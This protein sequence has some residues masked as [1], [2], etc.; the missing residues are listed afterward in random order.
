MNPICIIAYFIVLFKFFKDRILIEEPYLITFFGQDYID[1]KRKVPIL[2]PFI[3]MSEEE[4]KNYL[5]KYKLIK[6]REK[7]F[8]NN[9]E[10]YDD[11]DY[12]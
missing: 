10:N 12:D 7:S 8:K 11:D 4:E 2:I 6:E 9:D 3:E 1:Y 5:N